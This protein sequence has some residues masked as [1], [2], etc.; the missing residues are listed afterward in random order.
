VVGRPGQSQA[1][2]GR[3]RR[4]HRRDCDLIYSE[5]EEARAAVARSGGR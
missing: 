3:G 4:S 1:G 2:G 5:V